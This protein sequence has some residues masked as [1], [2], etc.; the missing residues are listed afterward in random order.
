MSTTFFSYFSHLHHRS[1]SL[2][3]THLN[4]LSGEEIAP[5]QLRA[6]TVS[7]DNT[8]WKASWQALATKVGLNYGMLGLCGECYPTSKWLGNP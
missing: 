8:V 7:V 5:I 3:C 2:F 1:T 4:Y 6:I